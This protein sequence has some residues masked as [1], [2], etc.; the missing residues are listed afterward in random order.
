MKF[1]TFLLAAAGMSALA[2]AA[3]AADLPT[4]KGPA[5][6]PVMAKVRLTD[7][8]GFYAYGGVDA[9]WVRADAKATSA[10]GRLVYSGLGR[11]WAGGTVAASYMFDMGSWGVAPEIGLNYLHARVPVKASYSTVAY[12]PVG[13]PNVVGEKSV[14]SAVYGGARVGFFNPSKTVFFYGLGG[15]VGR[16]IK[17][18][19]FTTSQYGV[20]G[21]VASATWN[22]INPT[23]W[24]KNGMTAG[25]LVGAGAEGKITERVT[26]TGRYIYEGYSGKTQVHRAEALLGYRF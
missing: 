6:A 4:I 1:R 21:S 5:P 26:L 11:A 9:N 18:Q 16:Q 8:T 25:Y 7:W 10:Y 20:V 13:A 24:G 23:S 22:T 12:G 3:I 15:I 17:D 2:S 14:G 19:A